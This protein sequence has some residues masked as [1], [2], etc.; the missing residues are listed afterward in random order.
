M[1]ISIVQRNNGGDPSFTGTLSATFG[2]AN[3][4]G[5][6]IICIITY[7][8]STNNLS[9]PTDTKS[10]T[11]TKVYDQ[12]NGSDALGTLVYVATGI[13]AGSNTVT[14]SDGSNSAAMFI[15]EVSGI[16]GALDTS[17]Q[18]WQTTATS[19]SSTAITTTHANELLI[20]VFCDSDSSA[21]ITYTAG[22]GWSNIQNQ[23][24][25]AYVPFCISATEEQIV[26]ATGSYTATAT[27]SSNPN[28]FT[29]ATILAFPASGGAP[30]FIAGKPFIT[31]QAVKRSNF[32]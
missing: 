18:Q 8:N 7:N 25:G 23:T 27:V 32:Y 17:T 15:Y 12:I 29:M 22:S 28:N 1:A 4:A 26:S 16:S 31:R 10:N 30:V 21:G 11:Y 20:G 3:T 14:D 19:L 24:G 5:N 6:T 13:A 9:A 2:S